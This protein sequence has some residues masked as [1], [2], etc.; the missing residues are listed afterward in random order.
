MKTD[1]CFILMEGVE[2]GE[3]EKVLTLEVLE[4]RSSPPDLLDVVHPVARAQQR[5]IAICTT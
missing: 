1:L 2:D 3:S 5:W 4:E